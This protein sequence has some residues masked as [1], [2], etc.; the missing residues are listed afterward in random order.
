MLARAEVIGSQSLEAPD[1]FASV[2]VN[3]DGRLSRDEWRWS[4][5]SFAN[6][7]RNGDGMVTR[8]EFA[9][10]T[11]AS[12]G[13][14]SAAYRA[15]FDH[16]IVEGRQ[17][18][19]EDRRDATRADLEGQRELEQADSG[20]TPQVGSRGDYQAGYRAAFRQA[21]GEGFGPE[22]VAAV[23]SISRRL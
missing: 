2:D 13:Q 1:T 14:Q 16:G 19:L 5:G 12:N 9:D 3:H 7:D 21:Y 23:G 10:R 17:A 6:R 15:G 8:A 20:Y 22:S 4:Q 11:A 18:G